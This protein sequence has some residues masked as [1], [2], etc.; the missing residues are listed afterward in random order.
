VS[1]PVVSSLFVR[2]PGIG[3]ARPVRAGLRDFSILWLG[4]LV[5]QVGTGLTSFALGVW[6][7][8]RTGSVT[9]YAALSLAVVL[10][11]VVALP[12][13]GAL[14][15]RWDRRRALMVSEAVPAL[16]TLSLALLLLAGKLELWQIV[17]VLAVSS[18]VAALQG[19][20]FGAVTTQLVPKEHL[21]RA[22]GF[23]QLVPA[24]QSIL[25][26]MLAGVLIGVIGLGGVVM[27]DVATFAAALLT[28]AVVRVPR[29]LPPSTPAA[30]PTLTADALLGWAFIR[31]RPGLLG[32]LLFFAG[33]NF[34]LALAIV[35][36]VPLILSFTSPATLGTTLS[37]GSLGL[38]AG[39]L[40][41]GAWGGPARRVHGM[42]GFAAILGLGLV[43]ASLRP[44]AAWVGTGIFLVTFG[45]PVLAG[46]S[47]DI[48]QRKTPVAIQGRV[49]GVRLMITQSCA[50]LAHLLAGPLADYVFEPLLAPGGALASSLGGVV[51]T[52]PGRGVAALYLLLGLGAMAGGAVAW[53]SARV[54]RVEDELP[55]AA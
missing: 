11:S 25:A 7:Y 43:L 20:A 10:P 18:G 22:A 35:L 46:C 16:G 30:R 29:A 33:I 1:Q 39:S 32:L 48:W 47:Q 8:Q 42:L 3:A 50:P 51:G 9:H 36:A 31:E 54:R 12:F 53:M 27:V 5:S 49:F 23:A 44:S 2:E 21:S 6:V 41:M 15:D 19:P 28:L 14:V 38:M 24:A 37:L 13:A 55:D 34:I 4:R 17:A 52:G 45:V 26:P 40:V